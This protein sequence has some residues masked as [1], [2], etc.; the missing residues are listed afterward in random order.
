MTR[1]V[2]FALAAASLLNIAMSVEVTAE[3]PPESADSTAVAPKTSHMLPPE[4]I[5]KIVDIEVVLGIAQLSKE[6]FTFTGRMTTVFNEPKL[7]VKS[8]LDKYHV[9][10]KPLAPRLAK[11][12][13]SLP[14]TATI[15]VIPKGVTKQYAEN[16][17][18]IPLGDEWF[19]PWIPSLIDTT[20]TLPWFYGSHYRNGE[21]GIV[22]GEVYVKDGTQVLIDEIDVY[23]YIGDRWEFRGTKE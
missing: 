20:E 23:E 12:I 8:A 16:G 17:V 3:E 5:A 7:F 13:D 21:I 4:Q 9:Q 6:D 22:N 2:L 15:V 19:C 10:D 11:M 18:T 14:M 1:L